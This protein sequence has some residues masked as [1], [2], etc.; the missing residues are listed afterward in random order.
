MFDFDFY[1]FQEKTAHFHVLTDFFEFS[2]WHSLSKN[3]CQCHTSFEST[4]KIFNNH[5]CNYLL[6]VLNLQFRTRSKV[7]SCNGIQVYIDSS[8]HRGSIQLS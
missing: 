8:N 5:P 3:A 4:A 6:T 2:I 1:L 7:R